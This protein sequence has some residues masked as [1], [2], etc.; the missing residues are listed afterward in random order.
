[1]RNLW[2]KMDIQFKRTMEE[3]RRMIRENFKGSNSS[4]EKK[5]IRKRNGNIITKDKGE[6]FEVIGGSISKESNII[7]SEE[8]IDYFEYD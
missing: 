8:D 3:C 6:K 4:S 7:T 5:T 2:R 1:M